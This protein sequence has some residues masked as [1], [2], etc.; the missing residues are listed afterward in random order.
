MTTSTLRNVD[1]KSKCEDCENVGENWVCLSCGTVRCSR[2]VNEHMLMHALD[3]T[4][5]ITLS[6]SDLSFWCYHCENYIVSP[7]FSNILRHFQ[8]LKFGPDANSL[9]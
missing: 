8:T 4:H 1:L 9:S 6:F 7:E 3:T 2:Y 5:A